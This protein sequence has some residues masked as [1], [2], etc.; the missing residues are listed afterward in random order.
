[1]RKTVAIMQRE[2]LSLFYSPIG[3]IVIAGFLL[4]TG[5]IVLVTNTI[6]PGQPATLRRVFD[7]TP[8]V[9]TIIVPA[10]CMRMISEEYR[11]GTIETLMTAP[12]S[13]AQMVLGK[14]LAAVIFY[15]IMLASTLVYLLIMGIFGN[16]DYGASFASYLGLLLVGSA[17]AAYGVFASSLTR[18]QIVAWMIGM[19]PLMLFV[20]FAS[21]IVTHVQGRWRDIFQHINIARYLDQF[22]RGLVTTES[23]VFFLVIAALFLFGAVKVVESKRWR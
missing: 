20:W 22:N 4:L 17:F 12:L 21:F 7:F 14:Y 1:M 23:V 8:Y 9:L 2:L 3:Y 19:I 5:V 6:A 11:A 10:I 15:T 18:N 16:P 13:D